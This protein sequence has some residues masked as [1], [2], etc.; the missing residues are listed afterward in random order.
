MSS[1][2]NSHHAFRSKRRRESV[3]MRLPKEIACAVTML[4]V[5]CTGVPSDHGAPA[6]K[7]TPAYCRSTGFSEEPVCRVS[8]YRL[9]NNQKAYE[10]KLVELFGYYAVHSVGGPS[11]P[12]L[13][14]SKEA[15]F[16]ADYDAAVELG[17][18]SAD[19]PA[20]DISD[21]HRILGRPN[22][23]LRVIGRLVSEPQQLPN[24]RTAMALIDP[25]IGVSHVVP[26]SREDQEK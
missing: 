15:E 23:P 21:F 6:D 4:L 5:S 24:G 8:L 10:G 13:F 7:G 25:I 22:L 26:P 18:I 9:L 3:E 19:A 20:D 12:F 2:E 11:K 1:N 16:S 17:Q 14:I